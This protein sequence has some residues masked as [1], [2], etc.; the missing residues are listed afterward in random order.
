MS[1]SNGRALE[2]E[3][4]HI[5]GESPGA[6]TPVHESTAQWHREKEAIMAEERVVLAT[7]AQRH[8]QHPARPR[9]SD[10]RCDL[11]LPRRA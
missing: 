9:S 4:R 6:D 10:T 1:G 7:L 8:R 11:P 3:P 2:G 5:F